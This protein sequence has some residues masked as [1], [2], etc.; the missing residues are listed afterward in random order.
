MK[1]QLAS[2]LGGITLCTS[3][4]LSAL[5]DAAHAGTDRGTTW[6]AWLLI[7][8]SMCFSTAVGLGFTALNI[9][10]DRKRIRAMLSDD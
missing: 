5:S 8:T 2:L 10:E 4:G 9:W 3:L 6:L 1:F 7:V